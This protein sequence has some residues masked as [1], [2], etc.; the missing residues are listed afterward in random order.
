MNWQQYE[1]YCVTWWNIKHPE[2]SARLSKRDAQGHDGGVDI[3]IETSDGQ[4][5]GQ[6]KHYWG[7]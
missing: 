6:C 7:K 1:Q 5:L 4:V 3:V 2:D